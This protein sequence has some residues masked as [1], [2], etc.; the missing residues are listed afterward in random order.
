M[1]AGA[2]GSYFWQGNFSVSLFIQHSFY[3]STVAAFSDLFLGI[4]KGCPII[5]K[6]KVIG[7]QFIW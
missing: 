6:L 2:V 4:Q 3:N 1:A 7:S 5:G